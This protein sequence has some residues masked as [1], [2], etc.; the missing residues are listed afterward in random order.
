MNIIV[1]AFGEYSKSFFLSHLRSALSF[2]N[3]RPCKNINT[4]SGLTKFTILRCARVLHMN[5]YFNILVQKQ[6]FVLG[7]MFSTHSG[8]FR[9][10]L[11]Y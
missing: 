6:Y 5:Y 2:P 7:K 3:P 11:H 4:F 1:E 9:L 10:V 8:S